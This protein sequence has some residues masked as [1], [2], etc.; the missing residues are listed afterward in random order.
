VRVLR[1]VL[2][3]VWH[4][5]SLF[6]G[7][8]MLIHAPDRAPLLL[9]NRYMNLIQGRGL[10]I[11]LNCRWGRR[12]LNCLLVKRSHREVRRCMKCLDD[13]WSCVGME[14]VWMTMY[15]Y[16]IV[17]YDVFDLI[18]QYENIISYPHDIKSS[19]AYCCLILLIWPYCLY[20]C[21]LVY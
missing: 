10:M 17:R 3:P 1:W 6:I 5:L 18:P 12:F 19:I 4:L 11:R 21:F 9:R 14:S 15:E 20:F 13:F 7:R 8:D 2:L 16:N